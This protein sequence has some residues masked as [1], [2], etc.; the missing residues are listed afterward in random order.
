M[1]HL[2]TDNR[3]AFKRM[4]GEALARRLSQ[5]DSSAANQI[6]DRAET[7]INARN[8]EIAR[9]WQLSAAAVVC[10]GAFFAGAILWIKRE[11]AISVLGTFAF[12][13]VMGSC[14][15]AVGAMTSLLLRIR[16]MSFD[17][18]AGREAHLFDGATRVLAGMAGAFVVALAERVNLIGGMVNSL[19]HPFAA[20][21]L[22]CVIAG[23]SERLVP[24]LINRLEGTFHSGLRVEED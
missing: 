6:L 8:S 2:S 18:S 20:L 12:G 5:G 4:V 7:F 19:P 14:A 21:I 11:S 24:D 9:R 23:A 22:V 10:A 16:Q 1:R 17:V 15:G 3:V 13:A